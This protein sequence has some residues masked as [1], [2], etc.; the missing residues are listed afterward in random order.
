MTLYIWRHPKP[1]RVQGIC[2]GRTDAP[3]DPRKLRRLANQI[4]KFARRHRL[5]KVVYTSPLQRAAGVGR[6]LARRG[7]RWH[8]VPELQEMDF[9]DWDGRLWAEISR[10][11]M[12]AWCAD[13]AGYAPGGGETVQAFF[14]RVNRWLSTL[15]GEP[16]LAVGHAGWMNAARLLASGLGVPANAADW[17]PAVAYRARVVIEAAPASPVPHRP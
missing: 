17:P 10:Q 16:V 13:F 4:Q 2:L 11:E 15:P 3:V 9:G 7:W 14:A 5:P 1:V 12:D 8:R 6:L